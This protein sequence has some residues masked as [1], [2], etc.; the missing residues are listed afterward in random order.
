[1]SIGCVTVRPMQ[2]LSCNSEGSV[3]VFIA[4]FHVGPILCLAYRVSG[5]R[6][7]WRDST[8]VT[9][10]LLPPVAPCSFQSWSL[11]VHSA[12]SFGA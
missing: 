11:P 5:V 3:C 2:L 10:R 1:M 8:L 9:H 7:F 12:E 4:P 6:G